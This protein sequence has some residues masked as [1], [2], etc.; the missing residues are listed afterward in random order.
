MKSLLFFQ[1]FFL[2]FGVNAQSKGFEFSKNT[3]Q[4]ILVITENWESSIGKLYFLEK[5]HHGQDWQKKLEFDVSVGRNGLA[6]GLG[7]FP[8]TNQENAKKEGD[9][10][11]PVGI[12]EL[13]YVFGYEKP[14]FS[15]KIPF[16][17]MDSNW[18]CVDDMNSEL[19]NKI[20]KQNTEEN[21]WN[22]FEKMRREDNQYL[23]GIVVKHNQNQE[24]GAGSCIFLHIWKEEQYPTS[25]CT[26]MTKENLLQI[27][28]K[29]DENKNPLL[30]Q[31]P[32]EVYEKKRDFWNLPKKL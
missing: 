14:D 30:I 10:K 11:S 5:I 1:I 23:W 29:L 27:I 20:F 24:I 4:I 8:E 6:W 21:D 26:A 7:L 17:K 22:S 3:K 25:G 15:L 31:V 9:G 18:L 28:Q 12:F 2:A 13:D 19:Y 16:V 32:K